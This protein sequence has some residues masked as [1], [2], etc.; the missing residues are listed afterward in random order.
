ML[1]VCSHLPQGRCVFSGSR[2]VMAL[3]PLRI[4]VLLLSTV[5]LSILGLLLMIMGAHGPQ[6]LTLVGAFL[7]L[8]NVILMR[9][10][11]PVGI[12]LISSSNVFSI[13]VFLGLQAVYYYGLLQLMYFVT[14]RRRHHSLPG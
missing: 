5:V 3:S 2:I 1:L 10:G 11:V 13:L 9:A 7:L 8:P 4:V 6:I 12:P 14:R